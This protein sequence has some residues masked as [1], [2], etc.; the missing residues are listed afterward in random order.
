MVEAH[1]ATEA[2]QTAGIAGIAGIEKLWVSLSLRSQGCRSWLLVW[3]SQESSRLSSLQNL[4]SRKKTS[5][6]L[7]ASKCFEMP[8]KYPFLRSDCN[9]QAEQRQGPE[10]LPHCHT[11]SIAEAATVHHKVH[12][13]STAGGHLHSLD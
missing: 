5:D 6:G 3:W 4:L 7:T 11:C 8:Q 9:G 1:E 12:R 2:F 13:A 10:A